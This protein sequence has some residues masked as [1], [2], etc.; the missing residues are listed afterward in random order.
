MKRSIRILFLGLIPLVLSGCVAASVL[1][2]TATIAG[3]AV[4]VGTKV[5]TTT[6]EVAGN[7][8]GA[9]SRTVTGDGKQKHEADSNTG[10]DQ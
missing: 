10:G 5:V 3:G 1:G 2:T 9:V 8:A 6:T 7:T 4:K